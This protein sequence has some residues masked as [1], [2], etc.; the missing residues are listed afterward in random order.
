[1]SFALL[2]F[3]R[4]NT[5]V[6]LALWY[7]SVFAVSTIALLTAAWYLVAA[8]V[9]R[10]DREVLQAKLQEYAAVYQSGGLAALRYDMQQ[11]NGDARTFF[12]RLVSPWNQSI[13]LRVPDDWIAFKDVPG[14]F[15]GYR[16]RAVF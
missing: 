9:G 6:R 16:E 8:D 4:R 11:E 12:V 14:F 10:K 1:M 2:E 5:G 3:A 15:P 13:L 7:A